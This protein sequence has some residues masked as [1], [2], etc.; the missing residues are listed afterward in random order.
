MSHSMQAL[1]ID[2]RRDI[3]K[4]LFWVSSRELILGTWLSDR[5]WD[6]GSQILPGAGW[7]LLIFC[8]PSLEFVQGVGEAE[9]ANANLG[10]SS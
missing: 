7:G 6:T 8:L 1:P 9:P 2:R 5:E 3:R 10:Y 4:H